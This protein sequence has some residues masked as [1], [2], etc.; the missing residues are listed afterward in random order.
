M[1]LHLVSRDM[2]SQVAPAGFLSTVFM[3]SIH[4]GLS[5]FMVSSSLHT[6]CLPFLCFRFRV[7]QVHLWVLPLADFLSFLCFRFTADRV[8]LCVPS[9][10]FL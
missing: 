7:D 5:S 1:S 8:D 3:F 4:S 6:S 2:C 10:I 9:S